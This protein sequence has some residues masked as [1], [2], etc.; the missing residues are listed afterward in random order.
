MNRI[1]CKTLKVIN[2]QQQFSINF[3]N[4]SY[5]NKKKQKVNSEYAPPHE[6]LY[7]A[8]VQV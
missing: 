5:L 3:F 8:I 1:E 6:N 2:L 4:N 7:I